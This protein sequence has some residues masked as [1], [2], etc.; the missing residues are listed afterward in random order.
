MILTYGGSDVKN[1]DTDIL[2]VNPETN[3]VLDNT[4]QNTNSEIKS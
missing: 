3:E 1:D 4:I 2:Q